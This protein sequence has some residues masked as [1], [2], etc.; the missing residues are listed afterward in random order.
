MY[1]MP[2]LSK[3]RQEI[4]SRVE[5]VIGKAMDFRKSLDIY[6]YLW[7]DDRSES[8]KQFLL[9]GHMLTPEEIETHT[10]ISTSDQRPITEQFK[11]QVR[12]PIFIYIGIF[13]AHL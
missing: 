10:D 9:L 3:T 8:M 4:M 6:A 11:E 7:V 2:E 5:N 12:K 1:S 13:I